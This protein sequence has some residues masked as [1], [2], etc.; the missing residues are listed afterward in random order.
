MRLNQ[1]VVKVVKNG[2]V[3]NEMMG[4]KYSTWTV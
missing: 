3:R 1:G 4:G 2:E